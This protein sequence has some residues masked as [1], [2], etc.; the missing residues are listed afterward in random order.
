MAP[1]HYQNNASSC[2]PTLTVTCCICTVLYAQDQLHPP[3]HTHRPLPP[4]TTH[5]WPLPVQASAW[6]AGYLAPLLL[7]LHPQTLD[8]DCC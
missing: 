7:V 8:P 4:H 1:T 3:T 2:S 6:P 5:T